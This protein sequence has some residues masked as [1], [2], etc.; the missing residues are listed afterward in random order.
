MKLPPDYHLHTYLCRHAVGTPTEYAAQAAKLGL[1]EIGFS[2]HAPM[3]QDDFDDWRMRL[4]QLGHYVALVRQAQVDFPQLRI[5][6]GLEVDYIPGQEDWVREL[7]GRYPWDYLIGSVHY[8]AVGWDVDNPAKVSE[9]KKHDPWEVWSVYFDRL[10]QAVESDLFDII[11][12]ADLPKKFCFYPERDCTPL[13][14]QFLR[15]AGRRTAV[16]EL[17]TAGLRKDCTEIYPSPSFLRLARAEGLG[18]TFGSDA[19][20]PSEVGLHLETAVSLA[21]EL[22]FDQCHQF[23]QRQRQAIPLE[24]IPH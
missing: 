22:G 4:D 23:S 2:D 16:L 10:A 14:Q 24:A 17:N 15:T 12:H 5:R 19:H 9:W 20:A 18:I 11:G 7:A 1:E 3:R 8:V 13:F 21:R 6:L